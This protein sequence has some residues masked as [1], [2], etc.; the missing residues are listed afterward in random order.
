M[1]R[2]RRLASSSRRLISTGYLAGVPWRDMGLE[3]RYRGASA[4]DAMARLPHDTQRRVMAFR[5]LPK[6]TWRKSATRA[7]SDF[8]PPLWDGRTA[9]RLRHARSTDRASL[10]MSSRHISQIMV[11]MG[12]QQRH[13]GA[14][15]D[16]A[17]TQLPLDVRQRLAALGAMP[18]RT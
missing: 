2:S 13:C 11:D 4:D 1:P 6:Q 18:K 14:S 5:T 9:P 16:D 10:D 12:L 8:G 17:T 3:Q 15:A 7:V